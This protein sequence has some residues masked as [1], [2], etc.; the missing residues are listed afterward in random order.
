MDDFRSAAHAVL[1]KKGR[2]AAVGAG[3]EHGK[4]ALGVCIVDIVDIPA[5]KLRAFE[6]FRPCFMKI[7]GNTHKYSLR[8]SFCLNGNFLFVNCLAPES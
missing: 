5:F 6:N 2:D 1:G 7:L 3:R 8:L 4:I